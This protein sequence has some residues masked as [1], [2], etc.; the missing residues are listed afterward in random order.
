MDYTKDIR[1]VLERAKLLS[2]RQKKRVYIRTFGR[3]DVF[4]DGQAVYFSNTKAKELLALCVD[5]RGGTVTIEE[6]ADKLW[7]NR[8]YDSRVKNLYRKAVMQIRQ[9][10]AGYGVQLVYATLGPKGCFVANGSGSATAESP[11][12]I[13]VIDTTGAGDIFGGSAMSQFLRLGKAP[14]ELT[15]EELR[16]VTR[17][18]CCAASLSTQTHGGITSVPEEAAVRAIV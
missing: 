13:H 14:A 8:V 15:A 3:F 18:A 6:A 10:L 9:L 12:G 2:A 4:I 1:E 16:A 17:F 5:H 11:A 7:E